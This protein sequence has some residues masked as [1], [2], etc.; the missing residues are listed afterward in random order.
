MYSGWA[1]KVRV[2]A[3]LIDARTDAHQWAEHYDR[4]LG[5]VFAIQSE[6]AEAIAGQLQARLSPQEKSALDAPPTADLEAYDLYLRALNI[7]A[8]LTD[9]LHSAADVA[10]RRPIA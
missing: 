1:S 7:H 8:D 9:T 5:D 3:Q 6:I 2:T 4:P 10:R